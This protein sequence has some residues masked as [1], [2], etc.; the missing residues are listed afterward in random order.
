[1]GHLSQ[2]FYPMRDRRGRPRR[3]GGKG[4]VGGRR[5]SS[6][7]REWGGGKFPSEIEMY[8][9]KISKLV[10]GREPCLNQNNVSNQ[11]LTVSDSLKLPN[12]LLN[13]KW[14]GLS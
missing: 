2:T 3:K 5:E 7:K 12:T 6:W 13:R 10:L 1:M 8:H 11:M 14:K 4:W 9:T